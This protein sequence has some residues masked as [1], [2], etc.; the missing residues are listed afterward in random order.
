VRGKEQEQSFHRSE[1]Q[2]ARAPVLAYFNKDTLT[3]VT[4]DASTELGL[5][6]F[7]CK[8]RG[9]AMPSVVPVVV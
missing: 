6:L 2:V 3:H 8:K 7:W 4:A 5:A 9:I 1:S